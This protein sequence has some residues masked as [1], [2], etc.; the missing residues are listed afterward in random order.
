MFLPGKGK[1]VIQASSILEKASWP[2]LNAQSSQGFAAERSL[3]RVCLEKKCWH[4]APSCWR[5]AFIQQGTVVYD[6]ARGMVFMALGE[7]GHVAQLLWRLEAYKH[8]A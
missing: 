6:S 2:T 4:L 8:P 3:L 1:P 5:C 7:V